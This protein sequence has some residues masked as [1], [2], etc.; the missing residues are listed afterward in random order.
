MKHY[1][2]LFGVKV[3]FSPIVIPVR[4]SV[5]PVTEDLQSHNWA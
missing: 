3:D 2:S 1:R 5:Q 4:I